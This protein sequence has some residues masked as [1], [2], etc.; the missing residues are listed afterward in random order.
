[1]SVYETL[2]LM[3]L[4]HRLKIEQ[5]ETMNFG[6]VL[7]KDAK[8]CPAARRAALTT[9]SAEIRVELVQSLVGGATSFGLLIIAV[10]T[11]VVAIIVLAKIAG[12]K[13]K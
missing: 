13:G 4:L 6:A 10:I 7:G 12:K 8:A 11:L 3:M 2:Y 9:H 1:M 5:K